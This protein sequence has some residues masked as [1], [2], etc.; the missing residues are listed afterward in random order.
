MNQKKNGGTVILGSLNALGTN[1]FPWIPVLTRE[2]SL[3]QKQKPEWLTG[4]ATDS[5]PGKKC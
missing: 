3:A 2:W 1:M 4:Q 5:I